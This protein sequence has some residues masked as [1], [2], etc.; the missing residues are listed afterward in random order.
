MASNEEICFK[1]KD[2]SGQAHATAIETLHKKDIQN[3]HKSLLQKIDILRS[4]LNNKSSP[5]SVLS[6]LQKN[7]CLMKCQHDISSP[8][9]DNSVDPLYS[10]KHEFVKEKFE[11]ETQKLQERAEY[12]TRFNE[13]ALNYAMY[14]NKE[15]LIQFYE[16][17]NNV[18]NAI[19]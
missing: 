5:A 16:A 10:A 14:L 3:A 8:T 18:T 7:H 4:N 9:Y 17:L 2:H 15:E 1:L 12:Q 11:P 6:I 19:H 13:A